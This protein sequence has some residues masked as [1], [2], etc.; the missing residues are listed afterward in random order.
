VD[1][2]GGGKQPSN[3]KTGTKKSP[4]ASKPATR[5]ITTQPAAQNKPS[6]QRFHPPPNPTH[7][8]PYTSVPGPIPVGRSREGSIFSN[9]D[10][11]NMPS[12]LTPVEGQGPFGSS[13]SH[14]G[15]TPVNNSLSNSFHSQ[16]FASLSTTPLDPPPSPWGTQGNMF[17]WTPPP[18][19][20]S[21][22][23][24][25]AP[26][27]QDNAENLDPEIFNSIAEIISQNQSEPN[28]LSSS[29]DMLNQLNGTSPHNHA[30]PSQHQIGSSGPGMSQSLL[31]RRMQQH[32]QSA[33]SQQSS[34][35]PGFGFQPG[36]SSSGSGSMSTTPTHNML[37]N[38][39]G[40]GV[41]PTPPQSY[42]STQF[43]KSQNQ[44]KTS[45]P[46][47]DRAM[48]YNQTPVTT[49]GGSEHGYG[50]PVDV[51]SLTGSFK[52]GRI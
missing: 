16:H 3:T 2:G 21:S 38:V 22:P 48:A 32:Q 4:V 1:S 45:W 5:P 27:G 23:W 36:H 19:M 13:A 30:G 46:L 26:P 25:N 14:G 40:L 50:S 11:S 31:S 24:S 51:S 49:P 12:P 28:S 43:S 37:N 33:Q 10:Y 52:Y 6:Q 29:F 47:P 35:Q 7:T 9:A 18:N 15:F 34:P 39:P 8:Q 20:S 17:E 41:L 42:G 44:P